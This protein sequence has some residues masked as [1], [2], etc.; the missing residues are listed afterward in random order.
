MPVLS[1]LGWISQ[2]TDS[3]AE[4]CR[5]EV[6]WRVLSRTFVKECT[7]YLLPRKLPQ[8][9]QLKAINIYCLPQCLWVRNSGMFSC[10]ALTPMRIHQAAHPSGDLLPSSLHGVGRTPSWPRG[11]PTVS[12]TGQLASP[13]ECKTGR[14]RDGVYPGLNPSF[15]KLIQEVTPHPDC[16]ES[17]HQDESVSPAC[18]QEEGN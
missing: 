8:T 1:L 18:T 12:L 10:V 5:Q 13:K 3:K 17:V 14:E 11:L 15:H 7:H 6:L 4:I 9:L 2:E 16:C